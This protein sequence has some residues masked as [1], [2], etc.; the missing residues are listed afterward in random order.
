MSTC[1][2]PP[3]RIAIAE[4]HAAQALLLKAEVNAAAPVKSG[5][6]CVSCF[7]LRGN[8]TRATDKPQLLF[9]SAILGKQATEAQEAAKK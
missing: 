6:E 1:V 4:R 7:N 3:E 9:A 2:C 8:K 5:S